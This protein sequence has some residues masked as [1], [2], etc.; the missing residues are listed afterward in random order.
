[1][2]MSKFFAKFSR[3]AKAKYKAKL[4]IIDLTLEDSPYKG[5]SDSYSPIHLLPGVWLN[6]LHSWYRNKYPVM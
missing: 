6:L 3:E 2:G 1:M 4:E 5:E